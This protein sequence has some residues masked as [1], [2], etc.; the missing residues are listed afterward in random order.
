M[1]S[2][3]LSYDELGLNK[4]FSIIPRLAH[5]V[6]ELANI[7]CLDSV[8]T[9]RG[10]NFLAR[11]VETLQDLKG[12]LA[13]QWRGE[14]VQ[15]RRGRKPHRVGDTAHHIECRVLNLH[16]Q[17]SRQCLRIVESFAHCVDSGRWD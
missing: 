10:D 4:P 3:T 2:W 5:G 11:V 1:N 7:D 17:P 9:H 6:N 8:C 16:D 12:M 13:Q 14:P 15:H